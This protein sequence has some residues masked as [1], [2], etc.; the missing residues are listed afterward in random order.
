MV[1]EQLKAVGIDVIIE[2]T[3]EARSVLADAA[4]YDLRGNSRVA[5]DPDDLRLFYHSKQTTDKGGINLAWYQNAE[6]DQWLEAATTEQDAATR[7]N[8]YKQI[9]NKLIEE[10]AI[11]PIYVFPYTVATSLQVQ[12]VA[13]DSIGYPLFYD[14]HLTQ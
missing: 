5:I 2:T 8:L 13:F 1:K 7:E 3:S 4:A 10:V 6:V 9:Q 12:D 11:I 14:V